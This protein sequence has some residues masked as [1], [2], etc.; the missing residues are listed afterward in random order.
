[1]DVS[2]AHFKYINPL[3]KNTDDVLSRYKHIV[4]CELNNGQFVHYLKS[5]FPKYTYEQFNKIQGLPFMVAELEEKFKTILEK[6]N[7]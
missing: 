4:V 1:M 2:L 7:K 6:N 5:K 3:P